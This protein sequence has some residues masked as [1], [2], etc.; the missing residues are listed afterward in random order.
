MPRP[1][2]L[3]ASNPSIV[4]G[5]GRRVPGPL[6]LSGAKLWR[7]NMKRNL[8]S[9]LCCVFALSLL[10][11]CSSPTEEVEVLDE[12]PAPTVVMEGEPRPDLAGGWVATEG[13]ASFDLMPDGKGKMESTMMVRGAEQVTKASGKW[14]ATDDTFFFDYVD[15]SGNHTVIKYPYELKDEKLVLT[16]AKIRK[17]MEYRRAGAEDAAKA[18]SAPAK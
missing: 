6:D 2:P 15:D 14:S 1:T 16:M 18:A 9:A 11:G 3:K 17:T 4:R 12:T 7:P 10:T 13:K 8:F 5:S